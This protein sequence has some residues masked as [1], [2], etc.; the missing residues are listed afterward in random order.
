MPALEGEPGVRAA[1]PE[2]RCQNLPGETDPQTDPVNS[3]SAACTLLHGA[4]KSCPFTSLPA[5]SR[6]SCCLAPGD[7]IQAQCV[8][9]CHASHSVALPEDLS[10][11]TPRFEDVLKS[12]V[13]MYPRKPPLRPLADPR[14]GHFKPAPSRK[15]GPICRKWGLDRMTARRELELSVLV[16]ARCLC[17]Y[18]AQPAGVD[19]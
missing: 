16:T 8:V 3:Q 11:P 14:T 9:R 18:S 13:Q 12:S 1:F 4:E 7:R 5:A 15:R 17:H 19:A 10:R 6:R 2:E